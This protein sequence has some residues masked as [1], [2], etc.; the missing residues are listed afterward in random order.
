LALLGL[1]VGS[2]GRISLSATVP[3]GRFLFGFLFLSS[4]LKSFLGF[5]YGQT[6]F[7]YPNNA[8]PERC[9]QLKKNY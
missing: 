6:F 8:K 4:A 9:A 5:S 3:A 1:N 2:F 7:K